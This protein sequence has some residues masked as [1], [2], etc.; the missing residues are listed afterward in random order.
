LTD[1]ERVEKF[2]KALGRYRSLEALL[3]ELEQAQRRAYQAFLNEPSTSP[4]K[5]RLRQ[6]LDRAN[7]ALSGAKFDQLEATEQMGSCLP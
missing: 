3:P 7:G 5:V 2:R 1:A 6:D 4:K